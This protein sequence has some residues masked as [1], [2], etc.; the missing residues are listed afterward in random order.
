MNDTRTGFTARP[1]GA[2]YPAPDGRRIDLSGTDI[3]RSAAG[4][5]TEAWSVSGGRTGRSYC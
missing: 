2:T 1:C 3:L 5:I 4:L